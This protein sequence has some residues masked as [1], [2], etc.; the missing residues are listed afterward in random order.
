[1]VHAM[2]SATTRFDIFE[3][4]HERI[5][6]HLHD[7][8]ERVLERADG[9]ERQDEDHSERGNHK[10]VESGRLHPEEVGEAYRGNPPTISTIHRIEGM[11]SLT[12]SKR[13]D[14]YSSKS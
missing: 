2:R 4:R 14:L 13:S 1:M 6:S 11:P 10:Q 3:E 9:G 7:S 5:R 12:S 8:V